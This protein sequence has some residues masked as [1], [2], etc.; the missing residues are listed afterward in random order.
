MANAQPRLLELDNE[1]LLQHIFPRAGSLHHVANV[2]KRLCKLARLRVE[3]LLCNEQDGAAVD[4]WPAEYTFAGC[5]GV[6]YHT[7]EGGME[8]DGQAAQQVLPLLTALLPHVCAHWSYMSELALVLQPSHPAGLR[9]HANTYVMQQLPQLTALHS[10]RHLQLYKTAPVLFEDL[11][12][13]GQLTQLTS[14]LLVDQSYMPGLE[15]MVL[16]DIS[17]LSSVTQLQSLCVSGICPRLPPAM[18][19]DL[20]VGLCEG[21]LKEWDAGITDALLNAAALWCIG[22]SSGSSSRAACL[23]SSVTSVV[24]KRVDD[25]G[26]DLW[27]YH[28][29]LQAALRQLQV[30]EF[31]EPHA[32]GWFEAFPA[33]LMARL[34]PQLTEL[35]QLSFSIPDADNF[36]ALP[37]YQARAAALPSSITNL[38]HLQC[39]DFTYCQISV[40]APAEWRALASLTRLTEVWGLDALC[41]P[42]RDVQMPSVERLA[43]ENAHCWEAAGVAN[44]QGA[45]PGAAGGLQQLGS[46]VW[47]LSATFPGLKDFGVAANNAAQWMGVQRVTAEMTGLESLSLQLDFCMDEVCAGAFEQLG[48][49]LPAL[50][51][52]SLRYSGGPG[53]W[54]L[55]RLQKFARI[56]SLALQCQ[57]SQSDFVNE[58]EEEAE[59]DASYAA[60]STLQAHASACAN[61]RVLC[62]VPPK[63]ARL[64]VH[65]LRVDEQAGAVLEAVRRWPAEY[66]FAGCR[67][68]EYHTPECGMEADGQAA[69]QVL[70]LLTALLP[71]VCAH[72]SYVSELALVLKPTYP[73][74]LYRHANDYVM[75][76]LPQLTALHSLRHLQL[77]KTAP[78]LFEDMQ[79]LGTLTQLTSLLLVDQSYM[80]G[81]AAPVMVDISPPP[82]PHNQA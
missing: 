81:L 47:R 58:D 39:M 7:F 68:V 74:G 56:E 2:C 38:R 50:G 5:R 10:L 15:A 23:P 4:S 82:P 55:P 28:L 49:Q 80:P 79:Q 8:A 53:G 36:R 41:A 21:Q 26:L 45:A 20:A 66:T 62:C 24:I 33:P 46:E 73:A 44:M 3:F 42:P 52:F 67:G 54:R 71:H 17:P 14:L 61:W 29:L 19:V 37:G 72:W 34:A 69:Q 32:R 40:Q 1:L 12:R 63:Q 27:S 51:S 76:Q 75:Q 25:R 70:P 30:Q 64:Q 16:V 78:L 77:Y 65:S 35:S 31:A 57:D 48:A 6:E 60:W 13:L 22:S 18:P 9:R 43:L 11:Q 59:Y